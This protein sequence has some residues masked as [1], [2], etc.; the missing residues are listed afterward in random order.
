LF[1][2]HETESAEYSP[3]GSTIVFVS[4][5]LGTRQIWSARANG[6]NSVPLSS[7]R[8]EVPIGTPHWSP[9]GRQI[10]YDTV[11]NGH[12]A[13][14]IMNRDGSKAHIFASDAWDDMMPSWSHDGR[15][16]YF[17]YKIGG[18]LQVCSKAAVGG[19]TK[20]LTAENGG[21]DPR[22][23]R[24]GRFVFYAAAKGIWKV[25]VKG[26]GQSPLPGLEDVDS[27]R[28]WTLAG[29]SIWF[30]RNTL[31]P[32]VVYR[33]DLA[34]QRI[35]PVAKIDKQPDFGSPGLAVSPDL[36]YLLFG[37]VD[38]RGTNIVAV[39]GIFPE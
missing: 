31:P 12:S 33:Y 7:V 1:S 11:A 29:N 27:E 10:V 3:D 32:W 30:V 35:S 23:S 19:S 6:T 13:I 2:S 9:D 39:D 37:Q 18:S 28:Y 5:R 21:S 20:V 14:G 8:S 22:E 16:I 36:V 38:E 34:T 26:G 24:D 25:S 17:T 4:N 15:W